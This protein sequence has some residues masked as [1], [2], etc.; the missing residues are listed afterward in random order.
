M[1]LLAIAHIGSALFS[2][3]S[4]EFYWLWNTSFFFSCIVQSLATSSV[5]FSVFYNSLSSYSVFL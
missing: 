1:N 3:D 4:Y 5:K 2:T